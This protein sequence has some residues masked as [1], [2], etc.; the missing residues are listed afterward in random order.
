[1]MKNIKTIIIGWI[2]N[3]ISD[4]K[5]KIIKV[6]I[7]ICGKIEMYIWMKF[8]LNESLNGWMWIKSN[9]QILV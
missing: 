7:S 4:T 5:W 1:M 6:S 2:N 9:L 8:Y 3:P